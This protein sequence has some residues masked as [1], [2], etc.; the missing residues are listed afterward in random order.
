MAD[1][2][3][4]AFGGAY[5]QPQPRPPQQQMDPGLFQQG[6]IEHA[7]YLGIDPEADAKFLYIAEQSLVAPLPPPPAFRAFAASAQNLFTSACWSA[8]RKGSAAYISVVPLSHS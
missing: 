5:Q 1:L 3:S 8:V 7:R 2:A 6:V 4:L